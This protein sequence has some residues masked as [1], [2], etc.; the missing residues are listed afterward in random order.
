MAVLKK[1]IPVIGTVGQVTIKHYTDKTVVC[2]KIGK[3]TKPLS[4][5]Q[6]RD[7]YRM[8]NTM[9]MYS[10]LKGSLMEHFEGCPHLGQASNWYVRHNKH[11][12]VSYLTK[13]EVD[14]GACVVEGHQVSLGTLDAVNH[15]L[16]P[17]GR[18]VT[19]IRL[20]REIDDATTVGALAADILDHNPSFAQGDMLDLVYMSQMIAPGGIPMAKYH[21]ASVVLDTNDDR[22]LN[23]HAGWVPWVMDEVD[24][25]GMLALG[26]PLGRDAACFVHVRHSPSGRH[27]VSPQR[28]ICR[29]EIVDDY[30]W[31]LRKELLMECS[32]E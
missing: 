32:K 23:A 31:E 29:N 8:R 5:A 12:N 13:H 10:R 26:A 1:G 9:A 27:Q 3:R 20:G 14:M 7:H 25:Q 16:T 17:S 28:L 30:R 6:M 11:L 21:G 2:Q 19:D 15:H 4:E 24:G 22:L 18:L